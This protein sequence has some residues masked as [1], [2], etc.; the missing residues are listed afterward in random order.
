MVLSYDRV[1]HMCSWGA[2]SFSSSLFLLHLQH[3]L[4]FEFGMDLNIWRFGIFWHEAM[5]CAAWGHACNHMQPHCH[6]TA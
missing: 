3:G 2:F 6:S 1:L 4:K 5:K